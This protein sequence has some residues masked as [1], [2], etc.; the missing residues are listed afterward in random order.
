M[1]TNIS[2]IRA[3]AK[4]LVLRLKRFALGLKIGVLSLKIRLLGLKQSKMLAEDRRRA[5]LVDQ[6]LKS[7]EQSHHDLPID[8]QSKRHSDMGAE[9]QDGAA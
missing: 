9:R 7:L 1:I 2:G 3:R 6:F 5:V 4:L 8:L